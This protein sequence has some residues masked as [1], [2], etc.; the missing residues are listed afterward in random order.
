MTRAY[1]IDFVSDAAGKHIKSSKYRILFRFGFSPNQYPVLE[2]EH[3]VTLSWSPVSGK[4]VL[5]ADGQDVHM[6]NHF[7]TATAKQRRSG[8]ISSPKSMPHKK[9]SKF[10]HN[11]DLVSTDTEE[12]S[13]SLEIVAC[14][15]QQLKHRRQFD[16]LIDGVSY[17]DLPRY[18]DEE[19]RILGL[20]VDSTTTAAGAAAAD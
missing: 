12:H 11:W 13:H 19:G 9:Q 18:D 16:L 8:L 15:H 10:Q 1:A 6:S 17:F 5:A 7:Q 2:H 20:H 4:A 3:V 14:S